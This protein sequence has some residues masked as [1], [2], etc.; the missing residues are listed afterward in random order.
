MGTRRV[1]ATRYSLL[2]SALLCSGCAATFTGEVTM[3]HLGAPKR[4][5]DEPLP[6]QVHVQRPV[7][8]VEDDDFNEI[9]DRFCQTLQ[10][11]LMAYTKR[12]RVFE[13]V[14]AAGV[15]G[16]FRI[17][18]RVSIENYR[19]NPGKVAGGFLIAGGWLIPPLFGILWASPI[20][21]GNIKGQLEVALLSPDGKTLLKKRAQF[22]GPAANGRALAGA[23]LGPLL[24]G[25]LSE[26]VI[27][28]RMDRKRRG[29]QVSK[30][31]PATQRSPAG[32]KPVVVVFPV[33]D[34]TGKVA[35][36][37]MRQLSEYLIAKVAEGA[38]RVV[39][40][41]SIKRILVEEKKKSYKKCYDRT[42]QI[43]LGKAVSANKMMATKIM[44][45][46]DQC[47]VTAV[48]FDLKTEASERAITR[49]AA[50]TAGGLMTAVEDIARGMR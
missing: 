30:P 11:T 42:C 50:C 10:E 36:P 21:N 6:A 14:H 39:P 8:E 4:F 16:A 12:S 24:D 27:E 38:Y 7:V 18:T 20:Y 3:S 25:F 17:V 13:G 43:E 2:L 41:D 33:H 37:T 44:S 22:D 46:G 32:P 29:E 19:S 23:G 45:A 15:D 26:A 49:R 40:E 5:K 31:T 34:L 35:K 47:V 9:K 1:R 48:V 28:V